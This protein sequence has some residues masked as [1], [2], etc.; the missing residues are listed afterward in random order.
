MKAIILAGGSGTRLYPITNVISKQILPIY[1]KP[2]I[3]YPLSTLMMLD[4]TEILLISSPRDVGYYKEL[5]GDGSRFGIDLKYEIQESPNGIAEAVLIGEDFI[6]NDNFC[7]ILGDNLFYGHNFIN[8]LKESIKNLKGAIICGCWVEKPNDFGVVEFEDNLKVKSIE[9]KPKFP[10]SNFAIPGIYFY[11]SSAIMRVKQL[12]PSSRNELEITDLNNS[13]L[14]DD[15]LGLEL[16]GRGVAWLDTGTP[17]GLL[18]ASEFVRIIQK[19]QGL[20]IACLEEIAW[21]KGL[22]DFN[23]L[24]ELGQVHAK[25]EY[26]QYI[27]RLVDGQ[28]AKRQ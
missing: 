9:E 24:K 28:K 12:K 25:S 14:N 16:I 23:Q 5:L 4:I 26:G 15:L 19:R 10:K 1:D 3:Y 7:L 11:D 18:N 21:R 13:Y 8:R 20:Y 22:I 27:L 2:M 17:E 6:N